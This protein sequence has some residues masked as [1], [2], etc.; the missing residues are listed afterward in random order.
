MH[1]YAKS[2]NGVEPQAMLRPPRVPAAR[3]AW[4]SRG[5]MDGI[6]RIPMENACDIA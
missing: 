5:E 3:V 1:T 4:G 2:M 6:H